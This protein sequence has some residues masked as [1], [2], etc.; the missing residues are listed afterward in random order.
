MRR[1]STSPETV[2]QQANRNRMKRLLSIILLTLAPL[3][4]IAA[5]E[6]ASAAEAAVEPLGTVYVVCIGLAFV[7]LLVGFWLYYMRWDEEADKPDAK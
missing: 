5:T 2:G 4:A 7:V 6:T 3:S 1:K